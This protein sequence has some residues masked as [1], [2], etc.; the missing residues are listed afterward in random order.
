MFEIQLRTTAI[1]FPF[2]S[3]KHNTAVFCALAGALFF[4]SGCENEKPAAAPPEVEV[5]GVLQKDV[6]ITRE[7][8]ATL[9]GFVNAQ[10]RAQ[11]SGYIV[12]QLYTNGAHVKKGAPLFQL[13][14]R[15]FKASFDQANG[16]LAQARANLEKAQAQLGKTQMDVDRY[17]PLAQ[18]GAISKQELDDAV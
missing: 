9:T 13:D 12:K 18:Q 6:P 2:S 7:W 16:D 17:T 11:V 14:S 5:I 1:H 8:V 15:T 3:R 4:S 10:I